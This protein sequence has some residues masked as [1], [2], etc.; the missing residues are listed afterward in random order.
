[1]PWNQPPPGLTTQMLNWPLPMGT[2]GA[3]V[4]G[5]LLPCAW[6]LVPVGAVT[7]IE[8]SADTNVA[9]IVRFETTFVNVYDAG[10]HGPGVVDAVD[11][12]LIDHDSRC[13][14]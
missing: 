8:F 13:S 1:M 7:L 12:D 10:R 14:A 5:R 11:E 6:L 3:Q 9:A 4:T 2:F